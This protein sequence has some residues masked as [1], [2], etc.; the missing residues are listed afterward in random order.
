MTAMEFQEA[1][2]LLGEHG[3]IRGVEINPQNPAPVAELDWLMQEAYIPVMP[4]ETLEA[5]LQRCRMRLGLS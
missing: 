3:R 5:Y 1:M 4:Q 2:S